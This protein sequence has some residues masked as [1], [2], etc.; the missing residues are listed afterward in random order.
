M[1]NRD[2]HFAARRVAIISMFLLLP[3]VAHAQLVLCNQ[4]ETPVT[5]VVATQSARGWDT[6]GLMVYDPGECK[7]AV[8]EP[9]NQQYYWIHADPFGQG[10]I[11]SPTYAPE[12]LLCLEGLKVSQPPCKNPFG[13]VEPVKFFRLDV[14]HHTYLAYALLFSRP[15][16]APPSPSNAGPSPPPPNTAPPPQPN[17]EWQTHARWCISDPGS[18]GHAYL[19]TCD[20]A[21]QFDSAIACQQDS[22]NAKA[23]SLIQQAGRAAV[24][25][26]MEPIKW[27]GCTGGTPSSTAHGANP[28]E[29]S[30]ISCVTVFSDYTNTQDCTGLNIGPA[31]FL[32]NHNPT[33]TAEVGYHIRE[34]G[35]N[36]RDIPRNSRPVSPNGKE[37]VGCSGYQAERYSY[38]VDSA[39]L[40]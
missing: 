2:L 23:V 7:K 19:H 18:S 37:F 38:F 25:S 30:G 31:M 9:L 15:A 22:K 1:S 13:D 3:C 39:T 10:Y 33:K 4:S 40:Y 12:V 27:K 14:K 6:H 28:N 24:D 35:A 36:N 16:S 26:F 21:D 20:H 11:Q 32:W 17:L 8:A 5:A 29:C 34:S